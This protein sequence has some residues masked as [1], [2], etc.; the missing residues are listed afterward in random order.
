MRNDYFPIARDSLA[1]HAAA[2]RKIK[3]KAAFC[4]RG[5][6]ANKTPRT[7]GGGGNGARALDGDGEWM[8]GRKSATR[9]SFPNFAVEHRVGVECFQ[10]FVHRTPPNAKDY[11]AAYTA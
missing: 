4:A 1:L 8:D 7:G 6:T 10:S 9:H 3:A 2:S 11:R 5:E